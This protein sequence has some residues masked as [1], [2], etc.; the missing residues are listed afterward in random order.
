MNRKEAIAYN[1][2]LKN[3]LNSV[4]VEY[5]HG[6]TLGS[7]IVDNHIMVIPEDARKGMIFLG[8]KSVSYKPGNIRFDFKN[9]LVAGLELFASV[10]KPESIFNYIQLLIVSLF[11]I[12]KAAKVK[13]EKIEA[14][15]VYLL[16]KQGAYSIGI[17]EESLI[18]KVK[19]L[20]EEK[21]GKRL[22]RGQVVDAINRLYGIKVTDFENGSIFL[23]ETVWLKK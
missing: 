17:N 5:G 13:I 14:Y 21:E 9:A 18:S 6:E 11:F 19:K 23:I 20:Y 4:A 22:D 2:Q 10:S 7:Y 15:I 8:E 16:H 1:E 12:E 3:E